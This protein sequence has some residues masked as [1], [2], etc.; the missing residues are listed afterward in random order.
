MMTRKNSVMRTQVLEKL[1]MFNTNLGRYTARQSEQAKVSKLANKL[2]SINT[3][4]VKHEEL[5]KCK[6]LAVT[7]SQTEQ[8]DLAQ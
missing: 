6:G 2:W 4:K 1:M 7:L 5:K 8:D 3:N